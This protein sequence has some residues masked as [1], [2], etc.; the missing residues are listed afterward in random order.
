MHRMKF[1][2]S[3][4]AL[5]L[6]VPAGAFA[7][8]VDTGDANFTRYVAL[9]DSLT[10]G[11]ASGALVESFQRRSYPSLIWRQA[12][13]GAAGFEQPLVSQPGI[14]GTPG[15]GVLQLVSLV[16]LTLRP[17]AG[18]GQPLNLNLPRPYNNMAVPGADVVDLV[19][20]TQGGIN[21]LILRRTGFTQLQQGLSLQPTFVTLWIGNNDALGAATSG[22][23]NDQTLTPLPVFEQ[24]YRTAAAAI[25]QVGARMAVANIPDVTSIPYVTTIPRV[26][27]NPQTSQPVL[28]PNGQPIPLIG[29]N[30]PLG[31]GDF[32]LLPAS[33]LLAQGFGLPPGIPGSNGQP[34]PD[35]AV[36]SANEVATI[37]ARVQGYNAVIRAVATERN[38]AFV[39]ANAELTRLATTGVNIGGITYSGAFLTGGVFSYD[40][41]HP[42][43]FGYAY[44]ANLFIEAINDRF[45]G[46]IP[47]VNLYPFVFGGSTVGSTAA[48]IA[49]ESVPFIYTLEAR[50]SLLKALNVPQRVID[51]KPRRR[52]GRG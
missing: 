18:N 40:G 11:F 1:F 31:A 44:L 46:E 12:T 14:G 4:L 36:L 20:T 22:I 26:V 32:V 2:A 23:V 8:S 6:L 42:N 15:F 7:Q 37:R 10:A 30:G 19:S 45:G 51:G 16:P 9:G 25:A 35:G 47:L 5:A 17:V 34:L 29:P 24:A 38:A 28:G 39:D 27:V 21:D 13:T 52:G 41:V 3:L 43:A 50:R 49:E 33:A 48:S